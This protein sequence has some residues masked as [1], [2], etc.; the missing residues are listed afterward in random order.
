MRTPPVL[1]AALALLALAPSAVA[2]EVQSTV[3]LHD[4]KDGAT[5][6]GCHVTNPAFGTFKLTV[7]QGDRVVLRVEAPV[8][9]TNAH[10]L[11][12]EG[13]EGETR[14]LV[15]GD[16]D[17]FAFDATEA[18]SRAVLCD[19]TPGSLQGLV[20]VRSAPQDGGKGSP[21]P[22]GAV[23]LAAVGAAAILVGRRRG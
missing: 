21:G 7:T 1:L 5:Y 16:S 4:L 19:G 10:R 2:K 9:N 12:V 8:N 22:G 17:T 6:V 20:I 13:V 15:A 14:V 3:Y 23:A 11:S 18:G